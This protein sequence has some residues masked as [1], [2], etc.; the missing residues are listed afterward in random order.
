[1]LPHLQSHN[2]GRDGTVDE[3]K[4]CSTRDLRSFK[5]RHRTIYTALRTKNH[6]IASGDPLNAVKCYY[7]I[8]SEPS[9]T[10]Q[11]NHALCTR[12]LMC[13]E[14]QDGK[15]SGYTNITL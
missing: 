1:M 5:V 14:S 7:L 2:I 9:S 12:S 4:T 8:G 6:E 10:C 3:G 13:Q 11:I 15:H